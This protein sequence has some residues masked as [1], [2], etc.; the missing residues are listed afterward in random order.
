[1]I[2][3]QLLGSTCLIGDYQTTEAESDS[4]FCVSAA[5]VALE[6]QEYETDKIELAG[7]PTVKVAGGLVS[8]IGR[9][10]NWRQM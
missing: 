8:A 4:I 6:D 3:P 7:D 2:I 1:M 5:T 9:G 10:A